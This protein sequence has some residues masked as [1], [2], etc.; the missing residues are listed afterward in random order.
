MVYIDEINAQE[1]LDSRGNP[2]I[3]ASI[4]LSDGNV[5]SAIVPSEAST[6]KRESLE[7]RVGYE[8]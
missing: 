4:L 6:G 7:F 3:Q 1:V 5:G 2:T 8:W